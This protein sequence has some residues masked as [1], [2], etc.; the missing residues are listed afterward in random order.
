MF[1]LKSNVPS[2]M[3][4]PFCLSQV[5]QSLGRLL[6]LH[7]V[8]M[9]RKKA[10]NTDYP[11]TLMELEFAVQGG[12]D[13]LNNEL[14]GQMMDAYLEYIE[15]NFLM[16]DGPQV[17]G[18]ECHSRMF[19]SGKVPSLKDVCQVAVKVAHNLEL[20]HFPYK[21]S[22]AK[23]YLDHVFHDGFNQDQFLK[24]METIHHEGMD[25]NP[26]EL[27]KIRKDLI[28]RFR[29]TGNAIRWD[30]VIKFAALC[31][32]QLECRLVKQVKAPS[33]CLTPSRPVDARCDYQMLLDRLNYPD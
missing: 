18:R 10:K 5:T 28:V 22:G 12:L 25:Y 17:I 4:A 9:K 13:D 6:F 21:N 3:V 2:Q 1:L 16:M 11:K 20:R 15:I 24:L 26:P 7:E 30:H 32:Y 33:G 27:R 29:R 19:Y 31:G 23:P 14:R 8:V